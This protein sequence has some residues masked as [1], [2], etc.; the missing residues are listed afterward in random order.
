[1]VKEIDKWYPAPNRTEAVYSGTPLQVKTP[2]HWEDPETD[3]EEE[4]EIDKLLHEELETE[5]L[6]GKEISHLPKLE[7]SEVVAREG[8]KNSHKLRS[9]NTPSPSRKA[10]KT[11]SE[12]NRVRMPAPYGV[13][14]PK[15]DPDEPGSAVR[16]FE[17]VEL[18]ATEANIMDKPA[19]VIKYALAYLPSRTKRQWEQLPNASGNSANFGLWQKEVMKILPRKAQAEAGAVARLEAL[20]TRYEREPLGRF[21]RAEFLDF[22]L[23]F[24]AEVSDIKTSLANRELVRLYLK[25]LTPRFC[26]VLREKLDE[27]ANATE[28][29]PYT[30]EE[31]L[32]KSKAMVIGA[33]VGPFGDLHVS[34]GAAEYERVKPGLTGGSSKMVENI[35]IKQEEAESNLQTALGKIDAL[36]AQVKELSTQ[37][38]LVLQQQT[39]S[40]LT[41][42]PPAMGLP[43]APA[44][45]LH[46]QNPRQGL[47]T[48]PA[49]YPFNTPPRVCYYCKQE[50]HMLMAC[51]SLDEDKR[52]G[53]VTQTGYT[54][55]VKGKPLSRDS[56]DGLSMKQRVDAILI[57]T[58]LPTVQI[59][60]LT[61]EDWTAQEESAMVLMQSGGEPVSYQTFRQSIEQLRGEHQVAMQQTAQQIIGALQPAIVSEENK[62]GGAQALVNG[63][64]TA[65][66]SEV[67]ELFQLLTQKIDQLEQNA[68]VTRSKGVPG[69]GFQ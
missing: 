34:Q 53:R 50:G 41:H 47:Y 37:C 43:S 40:P 10:S 63:G 7:P 35:R 55:F 20:V 26:E 9:K 22:N 36:G 38:T 15:Y 59:T 69:Q 18:A 33:T 11:M 21:D 64:G 67:R 52:Q 61:A 30:I 5:G 13:N 65:V 49:A 44:G 56:P 27:R 29:D 57:G 19:D 6:Q 51:S 1:M 28:E 2:T 25:C 46:T 45:H 66:P 12:N 3:H 4:E 31:V 24:A 62:V 32:K 60:Y 8:V 42:V 23:S 58:Y 39:T 48:R 16:F 14:H 17:E 68:I 54:I